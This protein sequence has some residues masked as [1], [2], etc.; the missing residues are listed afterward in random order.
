M[1]NIEE[2]GKILEGVRGIIKVALL[3][4][5][6]KRKV[7]VLE[8]EAERKILMGLG[9]GQNLGLKE[10]LRKRHVFVCATDVNFVWPKKLLKILCE[11]EV[12]GEDCY[13]ERELKEMKARGEL[14][15]GNLVFYRDKLTLMKEKRGE[16]TVCILPL[17]IP[18]LS[19]YGAVAASPSAPADL[20]LKELLNVPADDKSLGTILVGID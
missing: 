18:E 14:V 6:E 8:R 19:R 15:I 16:F 2:F 3:G 5:E 10:V 4:D 9:R 1:V 17:E 12:V 13:D 7:E 20:Y 11:G